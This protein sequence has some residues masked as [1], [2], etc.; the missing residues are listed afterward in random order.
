MIELADDAVIVES[1]TGAGK[2]LCSRRRCR[3]LGYLVSIGSTRDQE[4]AGFGK[5][6]RKLRLVFEDALSTAEGGPVVEDI[7]RLIAFARDVDLSRGKLL[8]HCAAGIS[9]SSAAASIVLA[10]VLGPGREPEAVAHVLRTHPHVR[11]NRRM[12]EL[13]DELLGAGGRLCGPR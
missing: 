3:E 4:P 9:R 12:L 7:E 13:A 2:I 1:L 10:V 11:P 8:V 5:V 6:A